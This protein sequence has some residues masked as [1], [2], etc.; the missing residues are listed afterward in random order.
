MILK[1]VRHRTGFRLKLVS[2]GVEFSQLYITSRP[3]RGSTMTATNHDGQRHW[4]W[5]NLWVRSRSVPDAFGTKQFRYQK[6]RAGAS[7]PLKHGRSMRPW[8]NEGGTKIMHIFVKIGG[9]RKIK[10][11]ERLN[12]L[13]TYLHCLPLIFSKISRSLRSLDYI[14]FSPP[15]RGRG[16]LYDRDGKVR[17]TFKSGT[18]RRLFSVILLMT[19]CHQTEL[20]TQ[21]LN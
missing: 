10:G 7:T 17:L 19:W 14:L 4:R 15:I 2:I 9:E 11:E 6:G 13:S 16:T 1:L 12:Y 8:K 21:N 18:E 5:W 3:T 20:I